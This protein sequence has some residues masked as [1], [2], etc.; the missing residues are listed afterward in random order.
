MNGENIFAIRI[1]CTDKKCYKENAFNKSYWLQ[2]Y[3]LVSGFF[4]L[5]IFFIYFISD[6]KLP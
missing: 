5:L 3:L 2:N 1:M 4:I 6:S